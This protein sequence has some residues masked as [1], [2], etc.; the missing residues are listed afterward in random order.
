MAMLSA[1]PSS[2]ATVRC[3]LEAVHCLS[4]PEPPWAEVIEGDSAN[5]IMLDGAGELLTMQ[6][7]NI[8]PNAEREDVDHHYAHDILTPET[9]GSPHGTWFDTAGLFSPVVLSKNAYDI[10]FMCRHKMLRFS[11][12]HSPTAHGGLTVQ[13]SAARRL[14]TN[15]LTS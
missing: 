1:C 4:D 14:A 15:D 5:F 13:R 7:N 6:P 3:A 10:D 2:D 8:D 11:V 9:T 12:D